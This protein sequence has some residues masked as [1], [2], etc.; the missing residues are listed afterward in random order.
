MENILEA[1]RR[2]NS[3]NEVTG[4]LLYLDGAFMQVL[5]GE[6]NAV[7]KT[8]TRICADKRHWNTLV[9]L[10]REGTRA[11]PDWSMGF[12]RISSD[13][14]QRG[15]IDLTRDGLAGKL[16]PGA[17]ADVLAMLRTFYTVQFGA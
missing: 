15:L 3:A 8:Y 5:E 4:I 13:E 11:F 12:K 9:L 16:L 10:D 14:E 2:N 7:Q 6:S 1:S 17:A